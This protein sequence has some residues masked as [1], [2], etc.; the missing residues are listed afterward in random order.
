MSSATKYKQILPERTN[1]LVWNHLTVIAGCGV[2]LCMLAGL[3]QTPAS[4]DADGSYGSNAPRDAAGVAVPH[5]QA[6]ARATSSAGVGPAARLRG[7]AAAAGRHAGRFCPEARTVWRLRLRQGP[8]VWP[9]PATALRKWASGK[10]LRTDREASCKASLRQRGQALARALAGTV[11][12]QALT[13]RAW[14]KTLE[15][16]AFSLIPFLPN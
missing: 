14:G 8:A 11:K 15:R 5:G 2:W 12:L 1:Y 4:S 7:A 3:T 9:A 6:T 10:L 13:Q 16:R